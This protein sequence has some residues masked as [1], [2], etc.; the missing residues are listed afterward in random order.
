MRLCINVFIRLVIYLSM[1]VQMHVCRRP[2]VCM[3][4]C[5]T[6]L[7]VHQVSNVVLISKK[8]LLVIPSAVI[9]FS[10]RKQNNNGHSTFLYYSKVDLQLFPVVTG[11][12]A[13]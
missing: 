4:V 10:T 1:F 8:N 3:C 9:E 13:F 12:S 6:S 5:L 11:G 7:L 2:R